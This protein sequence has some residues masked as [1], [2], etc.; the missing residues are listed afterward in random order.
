MAAHRRPRALPATPNL[1]AASASTHATAWW[2][3]RRRPRLGGR[4]GEGSGGPRPG[5][6]SRDGSGGLFWGAAGEG[7]VTGPANAQDKA[8]REP[9][10]RPRDPRSR[11]AAGLSRRGEGSPTG[12]AEREPSRD[13]E[14]V[15]VD[16]A[17]GAPD[18]APNPQ[19]SGTDCR[20]A[21]ASPVPTTVH[22]AHLPS[23]SADRRDPQPEKSPEGPKSQRGEPGR[24]AGWGIP[25]RPPRNEPRNR[26]PR[27]SPPWGEG[28]GAD[29]GSRP[30][31][32]G[33]TGKPA[34]VAGSSEGSRAGARGGA[35]GGWQAP[36]R[37]PPGRGRHPGPRCGG[38]SPAGPSDGGSSGGRGGTP[39]RG[40]ERAAP[41]ARPTAPD[42]A[43]GRWD[44]PA[45][46]PAPGLGRGG[47]GVGREAGGSGRSVR[48]A[49]RPEPCRG[50][51]RGAAG[52]PGFIGFQM[53]RLGGRSG[54]F[55]PPRPMPGTGLALPRCGRPVEKYRRMRTAHIQW[56]FTDA[57]AL[58]VSSGKILAH[59]HDTHTVEFY[60]RMR[61]ATLPRALSR[62]CAP[63][64]LVHPSLYIGFPCGIPGACAL[65]SPSHNPRGNAL[66]T[67]N[68]PRL[69]MRTETPS[70][71]KSWLPKFGKNLPPPVPEETGGG[72]GG[73]LRWFPFRQS[74]FVERFVRRIML[75]RACILGVEARLRPYGASPSI[76][77]T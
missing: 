27:P 42:G 17:P 15:A 35:G 10:A 37:G 53:P 5:P 38:P 14:A 36:P 22:P 58:T 59:A 65:E 73:G 29:P 76:R 45:D 20:R 48:T 7:S 30:F 44:G 62:A 8:A 66:T 63:G 69:R 23:S 50:L 19:P 68:S 52:T 71:W 34:E 21:G 3:P 4:W 12:A 25:G 32:G 70:H 49:A 72:E 61:R 16:P 64:P 40:P 43:P 74:V 6:A 28:K 18:R 24:G 11:L 33:W 1:A 57:C 56:N 39:G 75:Y 54:N 60:R 41:G 9:A 31:R 77:Y 47:W 13:P 67:K 26:D 55:P 2:G 46:G 51:R